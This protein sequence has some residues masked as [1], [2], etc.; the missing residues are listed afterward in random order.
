MVIEPRYIPPASPQD[1]GRHERMDRA[2]KAETSKPPAATPK[3]QQARFDAF[4]THD[5]EERPHEAL[6]QMPP[7]KHWQPSLRLFPK[8]VADLWYDADHKVRRVRRNGGW[9][10]RRGAVIFIG[11]ALGD[12]L[13]GLTEIDEGYPVLPRHSKSGQL[14]TSSCWIEQGVGQT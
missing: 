4:R 11:W 13:V 14:A 9:I 7:A 8:R 1:N 3:E 5:N 2:L 10:K 12:E 6:D